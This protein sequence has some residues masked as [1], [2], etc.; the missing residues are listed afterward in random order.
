[1]LLSF[2]KVDKGCVFDKGRK[3]IITEVVKNSC[4]GSFITE[5]YFLFF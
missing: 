3:V 1:M 5:E 2:N 4:K